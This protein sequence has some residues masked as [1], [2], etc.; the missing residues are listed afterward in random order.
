MPEGDTIH[1]AANRIRPVLEG[2]VPDELLLPHPRFADGVIQ[3]RLAGLRVE[4]VDAR[5]KHLFI[6]FED[7]LVLHSHLR[8]TG[9]W[10]VQQASAA[11]VRSMKR[12]W[13]FARAGG[14]QVLQFGGPVLEL[15]SE[16][17]VRSDLRLRTL[18]PDI[19]DDAPFD[20]TQALTR[21]RATDQSRSI[22]EALLDQRVVAGIGNLWKCEGCFDAG[23]DPW[24]PVAGT[25]D[26]E[27]QALLSAVRPRMQ[28]SARKGF[29]ARDNRVYGRHRQPCRVCGTPVAKRGQGD[30]NRPTYWCPVCQR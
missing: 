15:M 6:H 7:A 18:G 21:L 22:G 30:D 20:E 5:G 29:S 17:R 24:R 10:R 4:R 14:K 9:S 8:M 16:S 23:I 27:V 2:R 12:L 19:V 1:Y 26:A 3:R 13:F 28:L 25:S 11:P